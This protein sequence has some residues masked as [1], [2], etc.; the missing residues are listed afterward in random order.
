[1]QLEDSGGTGNAAG[2]DGGVSHSQPPLEESTNEIVRNVDDT[3]CS[4]PNSAP[5]LGPDP[6][7]VKVED[8]LGQLSSIATSASKASV[9]TET[10]PP[11][12]ASSAHTD[13]RVYASSEQNADSASIGG[14]ELYDLPSSDAATPDSSTIN[15]TPSSSFQ[16]DDT[17]Q[18]TAPASDRSKGVPGQPSVTPTPTGED[19]RDKR[20]PGSLPDSSPV[21]TG[22]GGP[23]R[24]GE[25][26]EGEKDRGSLAADMHEHSD[27]PTGRP[28]AESSDYAAAAGEG[29]GGAGGGGETEGDVVVDNDVP[30]ST[31][32]DQAMDVSVNTENSIDVVS[33]SKHSPQLPGN[34][35]LVGGNVTEGEKLGGGL[36]LG[37]SSAPSSAGDVHLGNGEAGGDGNQTAV[38]DPGMGNG[39]GNGGVV[40]PRQNGNGNQS[41]GVNSHNGT[42]L[43]QNQTE[44]AVAG[45]NGNQN[46]MGVGFNGLPAQQREKSVFLRLSNHIDDL[47]TNMTLFSIFL[48]QISSR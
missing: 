1:M 42:G 7:P 17:L 22:T 14:A 4:A 33:E 41:L 30:G 13:E 16:P 10:M 20:S 6:I 44:A 37:Q 11:V 40:G 21:S 45:R 32:P 9:H 36:S 25:G 3:S 46:G 8:D 31:E 35:S 15:P 5:S 18:P 26:E 19:G 38:G 48:D 24:E 29:G 47:Q 43:V 34:G 27:Q 39:N 28:P 23:K 2:G 12:H